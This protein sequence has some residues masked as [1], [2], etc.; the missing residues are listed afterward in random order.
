MVAT[1]ANSAT[2]MIHMKRGK[3]HIK[4]I[5]LDACNQRSLLIYIFNWDPK[6]VD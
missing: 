6:R 3:D 5:L 1:D 2:D 4:R